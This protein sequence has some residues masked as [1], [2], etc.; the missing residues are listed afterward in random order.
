MYMQMFKINR[1]SP[2][3]QESLPL[4]AIFEQ[5]EIL[6]EIR[7]YAARHERILRNF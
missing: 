6:L 1:N 3:W 4:S 5:T 2:S 7:R